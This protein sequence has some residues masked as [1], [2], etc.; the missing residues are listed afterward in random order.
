L[1][2]TRSRRKRK[3]AGTTRERLIAALLRLLAR[4]S[5]D[6][7]SVRDV[8]AEAGVNHG[9]VHRY[10]GSKEAL[11]RAAVQRLSEQVYGADAEART[12]WFL[13]RLRDHP[14]AAVLVARACLDGP[15]DLLGAA[16]PPPELLD[17]L[18]ARVDA[19]LKR[20]GA[21]A[22]ARVVNALA[23]AALLGWF[24]FRPLL[25]AGYRLPRDADDQ[26]AALVAG[27]DRLLDAQGGAQRR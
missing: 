19:G 15:H 3:S 13:E 14:D 16:A 1:T 27:L 8:A 18:L 21:P 10:F 26:L 11:V 7:I 17:R 4:R 23:T 25:V 22:D 2:T 6:G 9:L 24:A 5:V 12:G 20:A